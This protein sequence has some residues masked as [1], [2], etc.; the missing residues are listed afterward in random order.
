MAGVASASES[1]QLALL[2]SS[3][4]EYAIFML[5]VDGRVLTWNAGAERMKGYTRDEIV[6][7]HFST[8][9]TERDLARDHP[10]EELRLA[11]RDGRYEEEGWRVRK[12]GTWFW[13]NVVITPVYDEGVL[14]GFGKVSRDLTTRRHAEERL[15]EY[16]QLVSS[17]RDY[18][19]F[20]LDPAGHIRSWNRGA[21]Q[22]KGYAEDEVIGRHFSLFYTDADRIREHPASELRIAAREGRYEEEGWRIRKDGSQFWAS[23]TITAMRDDDG[24]LT[25]YAKVT[26]D[27]TARKQAQDALRQALS[28]LQ[29]ANAELDRFAGVAAH[30]LTGPLSTI[31]GFAGLLERSPALPPEEHGYAGHIHASAQRMLGMLQALLAF[32]R[33]SGA[34]GGAAEPVS[35]AAVTQEV[36]DDLAGPIGEAGARVAVGM[37]DGAIVAADPGDVR[38]L[39]QNLIANA[40]KFADP[41]R[42][43]VAVAAEPAPGGAWRVT[44]DDNGPGVPEEDRTRIFEPFDRARAGDE[45]AGYGLGLAIC[46]RL[47]DRYGG[48][49]GVE[50][51]PGRGSRFSFVIPPPAAG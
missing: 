14:I 35:L 1:R 34:P 17:V 4:T 5:D 8:F 31:A 39:L 16:R 30:D 3:A 32:A 41:A 40:V 24:R 29:R 21:E 10:A 22:L 15:A 50:P 26:R 28:E 43:R 18:A 33:A 19:I 11:V 51:A 7:R 13:A 25:G 20:M 38:A 44:V 48:E 47:V 49:L 9:Y 27:M 2:V 36:L 6:G 23:V 42:P 37:P 46:R 45:R 12:D